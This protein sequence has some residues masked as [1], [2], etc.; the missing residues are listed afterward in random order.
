MLKYDVRNGDRAMGFGGSGGGNGTIGSATDVALNVPANNQ[1]LTYD[2]TV[3]KWKNAAI[4]GGGDSPWQYGLYPRVVWTGSNWPSR[5]T[6]LPSG[7]SGPV[8]Y[9]SAADET[10]F[11]PTDRQVGDIWTRVAVL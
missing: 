5:T 1:V 3:Q 8:E 6:A 7:Y 10:A 11:A 9:W 2:S 4:T